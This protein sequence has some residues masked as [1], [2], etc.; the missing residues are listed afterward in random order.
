MLTFLFICAQKKLVVD[1]YEDDA[2]GR[3]EKGANGKLWMAQV[4][5][6]PRVKFAPGVTVDK[7]TLDEIHHRAHEDCFIALSVK[8]EVSVEPHY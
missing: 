3:L 4:T 6:K 5:L 1:S 7:P 2:V 8:T